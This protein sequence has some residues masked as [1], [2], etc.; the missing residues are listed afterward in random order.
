M[1]WSDD[2]RYRDCPWCHVRDAAM[3]L[4]AGPMHQVGSTR[5]VRYWT[6]LTCPRCAG[7][8]S[9]ETPSPQDGAVTMMS[10]IPEGDRS[11]GV[12]HLPAD[13]EGYLK[14][15]LTVLDAGV[16]DAAAV[17]LRKTLEAAAAHHD[18]DEKTL[19]KSIRKLIEKNLITAQF[20]GVLHHVRKVGNLG[21][22]ASDEK[23]SDVEARRALRFTIAVVRDLFEIPA[24]L[25]LLNAGAGA[26][27]DERQTSS[28]AEA[29]DPVDPDEPLG[30]EG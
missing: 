20:G 28:P 4:L 2:Y 5:G 27:G 26:E 13:V 3:N 17:Q 30:G 7:L 1:G 23:V 19:D 22:H 25:A 21:A 15:A 9:I 29:F 6:I 18:V 11:T 24:E 12:D 10:V 14:A 8:V 16:P